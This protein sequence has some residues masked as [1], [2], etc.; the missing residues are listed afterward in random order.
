MASSDTCLD[1]DLVPISVVYHV[2]PIL[3][4]A[5]AE[6]GLRSRSAGKRSAGPTLRANSHFS[7]GS[8]CSKPVERSTK[9]LPRE[10][11]DHREGGIRE[12]IGEP[13]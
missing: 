2:V 13:F 10:E 9:V 5:S 1:H 3:P 7:S 11:E 8:R 12:P 4:Q 6:R